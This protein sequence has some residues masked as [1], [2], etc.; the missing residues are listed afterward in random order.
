MRI[1]IFLLLPCLSGL[2]QSA[3]FNFVG[4]VSPRHAKDIQASSWS[5][6]AETM[7]RDYTIYNNWKK[8]LGPLGIKKA[9][10]QAGWAK[11]EYKEGHY[12]FAWLD[13]IIYDM[14]DQGVE[15]WLNVSY[16]NPLYS[17]GTKLGAAMPKDSASIA[18]FAAWAKL[19]AARYGEVIDEYE[20]WNEGMHHN[21]NT[22]EDYT[23]LY[24]ATAE[25]IRSVQPKAKLLALAIAGIHPEQAD[26]F[27]AEMQKRDKLHLVNQI[28]Y[29][30]YRQNPDEV[31]EEVLE[32]RAVVNRYDPRITIRQGE[33]GA[34]SQYRRTKALR[35]YPWTETSQSKWA[36][37]RM[38]GDLGRDIETSYFSIVDL[39]YPDEINRKGTLES[40]TTKKVVKAKP[41]Y[42]ALQNLAAIFDNTLARIS[43]YAY[44]TSADSSLSCFAYQHKATGQQ[45]IT[46]WMDDNVPSDSEE[47]QTMDF[48]VSGGNFNEAVW[49]DVR[50]GE[51]REIPEENIRQEGTQY[52][53]SS[54]P[55][56]DSP[57]LIADKALIPL[58]TP[59]SGQ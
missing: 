14:V 50:T 1:L 39:N 51:V 43:N 52:T 4:K 30:P 23:K 8:Y 11:T 6:G 25:A 28:T 35:N 17:G 56:Y 31:Y 21:R 29:H 7:D 12:N 48:S 42:Y 24:V 26:S 37:R 49:V 54:I 41:V 34:P 20:I 5:I 16:G 18:A 57:V 33:N 40:D 47:Y 15:P 53:F 19:L 27:L 55:V 22:V 58:T 2:A 46:F 10:L 36:L 45:V 32:L 9:R 38:L 44:T 13:S 3:G 59:N